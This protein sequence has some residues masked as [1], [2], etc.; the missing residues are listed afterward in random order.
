MYG[1][2]KIIK[3]SEQHVIMLCHVDVISEVRCIASKLSLHAVPT[4]VPPPVCRRR[5]CKC[6]WHCDNAAARQH[7]TTSQCKAKT[8]TIDVACNAYTKMTL[9]SVSTVLGGEACTLSAAAQGCTRNSD[10]VQAR[11]SYLR[12]LLV[13]SSSGK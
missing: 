8:A 11:R 7:G 6:P 10:N 1:C 4:R 12:S 5:T 3:Q 2:D 9:T 13:Y